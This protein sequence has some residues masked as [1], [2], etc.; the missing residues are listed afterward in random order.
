[1]LFVIQDHL[2]LIL[3]WL[4]A[5]KFC[6]ITIYPYLKSTFG[7]NL[8]YGVAYPCGMLF[9]G[10]ITWY[11]GLIDLP[12]QWALLPFG[13][14]GIY[15]LSKKEYVINDICKN[16]KWDGIFISIFFFVL[17]FRYKLDRMAIVG[18]ADG[19]ITEQYMDAAFLGSIM[20]NPGITP[21]DPWFA[22]G[23][24]EIYY[25]LG[26]WIFGAFGVLTGGGTLSFTISLYLPSRLYPES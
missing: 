14:A 26:H 15:A 11:F 13:I 6:Q 1:M 16:L 22:H 21:M 8:A 4:V 20:N 24:L 19:Y 3:L 9:Y 17:L 18:S 25:Y 12:I 10:L 23:T 5:I 7:D 2:F